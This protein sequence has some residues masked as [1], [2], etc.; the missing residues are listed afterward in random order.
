MLV[1]IVFVLLVTS[2]VVCI[3]LHTFHIFVHSHWCDIHHHSH[4]RRG[5][6]VQNENCFP[7]RIFGKKTGGEIKRKKERTQRHH[8]VGVNIY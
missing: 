6:V 7:S 8:D 2:D 4:S 1:F 3:R 5:D